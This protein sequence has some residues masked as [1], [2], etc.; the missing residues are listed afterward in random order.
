[1]LAS[2]MG[3]ASAHGVWMAQ[4]S[5]ELAVVYGHGAEDLDMIRR[6][7]RIRE[8]SAFDSS[9]NAVKTALRKTDHLV[10]LDLSAKPSVIAVV[11]DNGFWSR[12]ADGKWV[13]RGRDEVPDAK[14]SGRFIKYAVRLAG[15]LKAPLGPI[16]GQVL[17]VVPVK[18]ILP[19]HANEQMTVRV[20]FNG[21]PVAGARV[22]RDYV[23]D[24][25]AK[26]AI[27]GADGLFTF[28]VRNQGL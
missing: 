8:V 23:T 17:Q 18:P 3:Q 27:T 10:L 9:G 1:M 15:P 22:I 25:D 11:L 21:R 6:F 24:P 4:R 28:R 7:E 20:L 16:P 13:G 5:G 2:A 12:Q 19:Q 14:E 26:P